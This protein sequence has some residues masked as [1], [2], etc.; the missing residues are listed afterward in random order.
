MCSS[1]NN[2][3]FKMLHEL[4]KHIK[5]GMSLDQQVYNLLCMYFVILN[6]NEMKATQLSPMLREMSREGGNLSSVPSSMGCSVLFVSQ[7]T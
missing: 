1:W 2:V 6:N 3:G 4:R 5:I 7:G